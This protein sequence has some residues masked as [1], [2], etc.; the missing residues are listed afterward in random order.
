MNPTLAFLGPLLLF[1][2]SST[3]AFAVQNTF[4]AAEEDAVKTIRELGGKIELEESS[5]EVI[6]VSLQGKQI[7]D[8]VL[9]QVIKLTSLRELSLTRTQI[10]DAG[11]IRLQ[12]LTELRKLLLW[13]NQ[14]MTGAG[15]S[16]VSRLKRLIDFSVFCPAPGISDVDLVHLKSLTNLEKLSLF[17]NPITDAGLKHLEELTSLT[18]L[19]LANTRVTGTGLA[20]LRNLDSLATL[21]L[22]NTAATDQ[23]LT[24]LKELNGLKQIYIYGTQITDEGLSHLSKLSRLTVIGIGNRFITDEGVA[25]LKSDLPNC[26]VRRQVGMY[27]RLLRTEGLSAITDVEI[28]KL[29]LSDAQVKTINELR[30]ARKHALRDIRPRSPTFIQRVAEWDRKLLD[31]LTTEQKGI[32]K[33]ILGP[34]PSPSKPR[35]ASDPRSTAEHWFRRFDRNR[36]GTIDAEEWQSSRNIR[37][38]FANDGVDLSQ[39]M[40]RNKFVDH[41]LR[42]R[43]PDK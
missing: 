14:K 24:H 19:Q 7:N 38:D 6:Q 31:V 41:Y 33:E 8:A 16:P 28:K 21:T 22:T 18:Q 29:G 40:S 36:D 1:F 17:G 10:T 37:R 2:W 43:H 12:E 42:I 15:L 27:Q 25:K 30:D 20:Y 9:A 3:P 26:D 5:G 35:I 23:G 4:P 11:L 39:P 34:E 32:W 13:G